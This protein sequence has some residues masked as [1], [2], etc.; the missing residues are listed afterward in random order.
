MPL[1]KYFFRGITSLAQRSAGPVYA[2]QIL[3]V[4]N[5]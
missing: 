1:K 5:W 2:A 4:E 3:K